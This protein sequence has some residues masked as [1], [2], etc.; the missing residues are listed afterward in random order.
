M[1]FEFFRWVPPQNILVMH[2]RLYCSI[3]L[4]YQKLHWSYTKSYKLYW[5]YMLGWVPPS[6]EQNKSVFLRF[7]V[8]NLW[9]DPWSYQFD[10]SIQVI[11]QKY[12]IHIQPW[13]YMFGVTPQAPPLQRQGVIN[14]PSQLGSPIKNL[15]GLGLI[16]HA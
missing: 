4:I 5:S 6:Q 10:K 8:G 14:P 12:T 2:H 16:Q 3:L 11:Y 15:L 13:S 1:I 9:G 7:L